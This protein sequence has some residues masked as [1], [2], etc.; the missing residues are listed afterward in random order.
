MPKKLDKVIN[1]AIHLFLPWHTNNQK[2]RLIHPQIIILFVI[3]LIVLQVGLQ[4]IPASGLK[5]LGYAANISPD[6]VIRI[7][8]EQ[9]VSVG[10]LPLEANPTLAQAA[11]AKGADMLNNNYWAHV[12]PDGT[13]PWSF[14]VNAGYS[15]RYAG[16]NLARD[17]TNPASAVEAW[18]ASP[19][20]KDNLLSANYRDIGIAVI[21]GDLDG[22]DTTIIVQF[23]GTKYTDTVPSV[24]IAEAQPASTEA[25]QF[26][27]SPAPVAATF[28][29]PSPESSLVAVQTPI[30][31]AGPIG[32]RVLISPFSTTKGVSLVVVGL[33]LNVLVF[34][35]LITRRRRIARIGGRTFAH[36]SF[37]GMVLAIVLILKAGQVI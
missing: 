3:K 30:A 2:A 6:E 10:L 35:G 23:F 36:L 31:E 8:N 13:Q 9:R 32:G 25:P 27:P 4:F 11:Q 19:T 29:S 5:I 33:L 16:E 15:Y 26:S 20:H 37:L 24:P 21:E 12:S 17:F 22:V 18:M 7:T 28:P 14:F 1:R 34:D